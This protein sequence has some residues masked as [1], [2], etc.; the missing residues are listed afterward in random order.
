M[1]N[2]Q[3]MKYITPIINFWKKQTK[4]KK[5]IFVW[6][7]GGL[8]VLSFVIMLLM[9]FSAYTV[10]YS[11]MDETETS[12]V[13]KLLESE[14]IKCKLGSDGD[15]LV[16]KDKV[17]SIR[18]E[19]AIAGYPESTT[20][21]DVFTSNIDLMTTDYEK[22]QL[23]I[24]QLNERLETTIETIKAV[25]SA[26]VTISIPDNSGYAWEENAQQASASVMVEV[27]NEATLTASQVNGIKQLVAKSV[28]GLETSQVVVVDSSGTQLQSSE[29]MTQL[30]IAELSLTIKSKFEADITAKIKNILDPIFGVGNMR[31]P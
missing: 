30:N 13:V 31:F 23:K 25:K 18:M 7:L 28:P 17:D 9:N 26:I 1:K 11:G 2:E 10:L 14:G 29:D 4:R 12:Q 24:Y 15:I 5:M 19:L 27:E 22:R 8:V 20:N 6:G 16:P 3:M 21:Y